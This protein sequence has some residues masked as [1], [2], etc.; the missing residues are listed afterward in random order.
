MK[1]NFGVNI[2]YPTYSIFIKILNTVLDF[3]L[4][5]FIYKPFC[6][7]NKQKISFVSYKKSRCFLFHF[8]FLVL[9]QFNPST[10]IQQI[11]S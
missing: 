6:L 9:L 4:Y 7:W 8:L 5:E 3:D 11:A 10:H 1:I 2:F